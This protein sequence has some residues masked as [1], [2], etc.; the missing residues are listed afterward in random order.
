ME[1]HDKSPSPK[2]QLIICVASQGE[3]HEVTIFHLHRGQQEPQRVELSSLYLSIVLGNVEPGSI[4]PSNVMEKLEPSSI[5]P[6]KVI[7]KVE[8][9]SYLFPL[10]QAIYQFH[11][12]PEYEQCTL[13]V[14][15]KKGKDT[16]EPLLK[17]TL[18]KGHLCIKNAP[19]YRVAMYFYL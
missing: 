1:S 11:S 4:R 14:I 18:N 12:S 2:S 13:H 16:V 10:I 6:S 5:Q 3:V 8:P 9:N 19:T 7:G 17:D 15:M